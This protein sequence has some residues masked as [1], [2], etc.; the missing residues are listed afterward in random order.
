VNVS[1]DTSKKSDAARNKAYAAANARLRD[2]FRER[3]NAL[4]SEE[5]AALGLTPRRRRTAEE[6]EAEEVAKRII[7]EEKAEMKRLEKIA[8]LQAEIE[9][10]KGEGDP[11]DVFREPASV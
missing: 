10:L 6:I 4:L 2:E 8:R 7:R 3:F 1:E 9:A 11:M 5:Y